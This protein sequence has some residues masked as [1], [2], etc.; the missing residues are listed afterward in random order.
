LIDRSGYGNHGT[1]TNMTS[2]DWVVSQGAGAL[3]FDGVNDYVDCGVLNSR[4]FGYPFAWSCWIRNL[5]T[6]NPD[7]GI[8]SKISVGTAPFYAGV[9]MWLNGGKLNAYW[10]SAIRATSATTVTNNANWMQVGI[11]WTGTIARV[12]INGKIDAESATTTPP[13]AA[14]DSFRI[15]DYPYP[16]SRA[17]KFEFDD[18]RVYDRPLTSSEW[19]LLASRRGI[20]LQP[21]PKQFTYYQFPSGS[22]RRRILTGMP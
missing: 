14:T 13:S 17:A 20:G 6:T 1:L 7:A 2:E 22:K 8:M 4:S 5:S 12:W 10:A 19:A 9:Q 18:G 3:D 16:D 15:G 11:E 21:R